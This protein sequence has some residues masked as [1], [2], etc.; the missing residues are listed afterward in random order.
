[1]HKGN[2]CLYISHR[3]IDGPFDAVYD[4]YLYPINAKN[5]ETNI[6]VTVNSLLVQAP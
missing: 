5:Y 4:L 3:P 6:T 1:M 2:N